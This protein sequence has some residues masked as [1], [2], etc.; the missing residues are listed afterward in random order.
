MAKYFHRLPNGD[1]Q[2]FD[3]YEEYLQDLKRKERKESCPIITMIVVGVL[4]IMGAIWQWDAADPVGNFAL[5]GFGIWTIFFTA[6]AFLA[7]CNKG[8]LFGILM[9]I[10]GM[11]PLFIV[12]DAIVGFNVFISGITWLRSLFG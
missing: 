12:L 10:I 4:F 5:L 2:M 11:I 6:W 8:N 7:G 1:F 3:S 9:L